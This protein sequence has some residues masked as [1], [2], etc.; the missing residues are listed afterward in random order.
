MEEWEKLVIYER[1][2]L[3]ICQRYNIAETVNLAYKRSETNK[4]IRNQKL[5]ILTGHL[6]KKDS[7]FSSN[8]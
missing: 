8:N 2:F 4:S 7:S 6:E 3:E 1:N 5:E